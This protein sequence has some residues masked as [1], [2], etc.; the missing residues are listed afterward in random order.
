MVAEKSAWLYI[1]FHS[2]AWLLQLS[3]GCCLCTDPR[4]DPVDPLCSA[5][6][7]VWDKH[8]SGIIIK[9]STMSGVKHLNNNSTIKHNSICICTFLTCSHWFS[10]PVSK[11]ALEPKRRLPLLL[12]EGGLGWFSCAKKVSRVTTSCLTS[13]VQLWKQTAVIADMCQFA[14]LWEFCSDIWLPKQRQFVS[15]NLFPATIFLGRSLANGG[16][17]YPQAY[18]KF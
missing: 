3:L 12:N 8:L 16:Y 6:N 4:P 5:W 14:I 18:L 9:C 17:F 7:N 13:N 10:K 11:F 2:H 1:L 15:F